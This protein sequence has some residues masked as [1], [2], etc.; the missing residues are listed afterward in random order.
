MTHGWICKKISFKLG[1]TKFLKKKLSGGGL[2]KIKKNFI[3]I[4]LKYSSSH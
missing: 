2:K 4:T 3:H 1:K